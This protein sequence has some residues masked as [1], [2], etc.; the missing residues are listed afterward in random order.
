MQDCDG[1]V[2]DLTVFGKVYRYFA[3]HKTAPMRRTPYMFTKREVDVLSSVYTFL[4]ETI[5]L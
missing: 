2:V 4:Y 3:S 5:T 1:L